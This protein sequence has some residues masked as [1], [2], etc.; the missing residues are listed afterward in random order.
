[1]NDRIKLPFLLYR[2]MGRLMLELPALMYIWRDVA[3]KVKTL[4][5]GLWDQT[6]SPVTVSPVSS[7]HWK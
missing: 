5:W 2:I 7:F 6:V 4:A 1:M 3:N